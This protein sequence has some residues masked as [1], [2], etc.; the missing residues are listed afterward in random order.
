MWPLAPEE[1]LHGTVSWNAV[2]PANLGSPRKV[3]YQL[4]PTSMSKGPSTL[5]GS[6]N[7][8]QNPTPAFGAKEEQS[9]M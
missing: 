1:V 3:P 2:M 9:Q 5:G 6:Q 7:M 8:E 4:V